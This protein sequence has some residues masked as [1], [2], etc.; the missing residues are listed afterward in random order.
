MH[1]VKR[2]RDPAQDELSPVTRA[3]T[4]HDAAWPVGAS[5][6]RIRETG[7]IDEAS[8]ELL[9]S[10]D[11]TDFVPTAR[12]EHDGAPAKKIK[13]YRMGQNMKVTIR[14]FHSSAQTQVYHSKCIGSGRWK[15]VFLLQGAG[16]RFHNQVLKVT[17]LHWPK[18]D[19]Q[20]DVEPRAFQKLAHTQKTLRILDEF[21]GADQHNELHHCWITE[22]AIP[23]G[24]LLIADVLDG[25]SLTVSL[26]YLVARLAHE[27]QFYITDCG[28]NNFGMRLART[29]AAT[30]R[31]DHEVILIDGGHR[32]LAPDQSHHRSKCNQALSS[33]W[34]VTGQFAPEATELMRNKQ[35]PAS[36]MPDFLN[37]V[38]TT[39][40]QMPGIVKHTQTLEKII[41]ETCCGAESAST[42]D[43]QS[44]R[45]MEISLP[46]ARH[47][48]N[49]ERT[50]LEQESESWIHVANLNLLDTERASSS[51]LP[52][53]QE[54]IAA[55]RQMIAT[56]ADE[57]RIDDAIKAVWE[58]AY[59]AG[60]REDV[61]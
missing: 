33:L 19:R 21:I 25:P 44:H 29:W 6:E 34:K 49:A 42:S 30:P 17:K 11:T 15:E 26:T 57:Q 1:Q 48:S 56:T 28:I 16:S 23:L 51:K 31:I 20:L 4:Q 38:K 2:F 22:R 47:I 50:A 43:A 58:L 60:R 14:R 10:V 36:S 52:Q 46:A 55:L 39:A 35:T 12:L 24:K 32:D 53:R 5:A 27:E 59:A 13:Q 61:D 40:E 18:Y 7:R 3:S 41:I 8:R 54:V 9:A 45:P 37:Y